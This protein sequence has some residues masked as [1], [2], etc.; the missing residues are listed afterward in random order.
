[1]VKILKSMVIYCNCHLLAN[2]NDVIGARSSVSVYAAPNYVPTLK[3]HFFLCLHI[4]GAHHN[5]RHSIDFH[6]NYLQNNGHFHYCIHKLEIGR[7]GTREGKREK[8]RQN[9][10]EFLMQ[11]RTKCVWYCNFIHILLRFILILFNLPLCCVNKLDKSFN[12]LS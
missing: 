2:H 9:S 11:T 12:S 1:M 6:L 5:I 10:T 4:N 8:E 7:N 3:I